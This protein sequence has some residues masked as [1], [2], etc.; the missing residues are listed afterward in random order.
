MSADAL[1][2]H[3]AYRETA[4]SRGQATAPLAK[5]V[6]VVVEEKGVGIDAKPRVKTR[7]IQ[8]TEEKQQAMALQNV[9]QGEGT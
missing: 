4:P 3:Q 5:V 7:R 1:S 6:V 9:Q 8:R 2:A